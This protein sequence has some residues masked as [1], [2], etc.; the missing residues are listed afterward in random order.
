MVP[1][2][3]PRICMQ[4]LLVSGAAPDHMQ[5]SQQPATQQA[6]AQ[7]LLSPTCSCRCHR[8]NIGIRTV[9]HFAMG[10]ELCCDLKSLE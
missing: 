2:P 6:A 4:P 8:R 1:W 9:L 5:P 10:Q 3:T 7:Q